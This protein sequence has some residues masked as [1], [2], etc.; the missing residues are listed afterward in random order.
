MYV[1]T[2][3]ILGSA[4][5]PFSPLPTLLLPF[6]PLSPPPLPATKRLIFHQSLVLHPPPLHSR[7]FFRSKTLLFH[8][9][10]RGRFDPTPI[11]FDLSVSSPVQP[12]HTIPKH[13]CKHL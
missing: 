10:I 5:A 7:H 1:C 4:T 13:P 2:V 8:S 9:L 6:P 11:T 3:H 12:P